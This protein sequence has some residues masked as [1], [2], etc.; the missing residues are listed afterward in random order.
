MEALRRE[1]RWF[2]GVKDGKIFDRSMELVVGSGRAERLRRTFRI[3]IELAIA[4]PGNYR[5]TGRLPLGVSLTTSVWH[6]LEP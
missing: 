3:A 2:G 6:G 5:G 1:M 4:Q